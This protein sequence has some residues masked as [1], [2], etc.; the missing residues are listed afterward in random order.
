MK[1]A[2]V[3]HDAWS[4]ALFD[5]AAR[6]VT[7]LS[8]ITPLTT[9]EA[10]SVRLYSGRRHFCRRGCEAFPSL[11]RARAMALEHG[12]NTILLP[13]L[14]CMEQLL[15]RG[16]QLG[17][18]MATWETA[19]ISHLPRL[20]EAACQGNTQLGSL[21]QLREA[22]AGML[23]VLHAMSVAGEKAQVSSLWCKNVQRVHLQHVQHVSSMC[24]MHLVLR[25]SL[26]SPHACT[27]SVNPGS[28]P[29]CHWQESHGTCLSVTCRQS[30]G[31]SIS[32][33]RLLRKAAH[34][35]GHCPAISS[36][37]QS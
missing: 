10:P 24:A 15:T 12:L 1:T 16:C 20:V 6:V 31:N 23:R 5:S 8:C 27:L 30:P 35:L 25:R 7:A 37:M 26:P 34:M 9:S 2:Y 29:C 22:T 28:L 13:I 36:L 19:R 32:A 21:A 14:D 11:L 3:A 33:Y 18:C 4:K 17:S